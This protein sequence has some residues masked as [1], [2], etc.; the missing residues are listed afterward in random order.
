MPSRLII[1]THLQ[2]NYQTSPHSSPHLPSPHLSTLIAGRSTIP[3]APPPFTSPLPSSLSLSLSIYLSISIS[4]PS[5][6]CISAVSGGLATAGFF[7]DER[8]HLHTRLSPP[9]S[10]SLAT[11]SRS[12]ASSLPAAPKLRRLAACELRPT[13]DCPELHHQFFP[14][15]QFNNKIKQQL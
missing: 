6:G 13:S 14:Q 15:H 8:A 10:P 3:A 12:L 7:P 1:R 11:V 9:F 4:L 5:L 2:L